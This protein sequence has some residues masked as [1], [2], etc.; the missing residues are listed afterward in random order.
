MTPE[1]HDFVY[2]LPEINREE[3]Q[4]AQH[5]ANPG[6]FAT[7]IQVA[8][9]PAAYLNLLK[10]DSKKRRCTSFI[11]DI[12]FTVLL[13]GAGLSM[14]L[15]TKDDADLS[16]EIMPIGITIGI[17]GL[18]LTVLLIIISKIYKEKD[19]EITVE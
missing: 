1:H 7:C 3:I 17:I 6:C 5:V 14:V 12:V 8:L 19:P 15:L 4:K 2:G 18:V 16:A 13:F 11:I 9:L 10:E